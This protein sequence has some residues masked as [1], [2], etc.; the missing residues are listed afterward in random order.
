MFLMSLRWRSLIA[1]T[2]TVVAL[3]GAGTAYAAPAPVAAPAGFSAAQLV[4]PYPSDIPPGGTYIRELDGFAALRTEHPEVLRQN[5][6]KAISFNN[7]ATPAQQADALAINYDDRIVSLSE[8]MGTRVGK[9]FR[10]LL[11]AGKL[12]K[13]A[14]LAE[15][16]TSRAG[17]PLQHSLIEKQYYDN[18]RPFVVAPQQIKRYN[19]PGSDLYPALAG[20]GSYPSGHSTQGYWMAALMS[21]WLPELGPQLM[22]RAGEIG[23]GRMVLGVHY[24]L[25]VMG[26]RIL[27]LT[28]ASERLSDPGFAKLIDEAGVQLRAQLTS[29]LGAPVEQAIASDTGTLSDAQALAESREQMT[30]GFAR[31]APN[32]VNDIPAEAAALLRA[33]YPHLT[34]A[35]RLDKLRRTAIPTGYPLDQSGANGGWLRIDLAAA[36]AD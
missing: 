4:G 5:L 1:S 33:R 7:N 15:G 35:Q 17:L 20:N 29:K 32:Q 28:V 6:A 13:V 26:G 25:D 34:D 19:R 21:Y 31:I 16:E 9:A 24:P 14:Q 36:L 23:L 27:G 22:V 10:D 12:P 2:L 3:A 8:A 18:P 11:A 30:W